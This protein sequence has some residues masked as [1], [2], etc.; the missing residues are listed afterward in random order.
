MVTTPRPIKERIE[1]I[2]VLRGFALL[3]IIIVHFVEQYYAGDPPAAIGSLNVKTLADE[4][5]TAV[6]GIFI[7][8]KFYIIFS[9]LFGLSFYVQLNNSDGTGKFFVR[10]AWR[11]IVLFALGFI[12]HLH[13]RGDIL[14][15]YA[16]LGFGLLL[17]S[18]LPDRALL[19]VALL[20]ILNVPSVV[21]RLYETT[22]PETPTEFFNPKQEEAY[23]YTVKSGTYL[24]ILKANFYEFETKA[25]VQ[26]LSGRA[27]ITLGLF[28][29]GLY[30]GRKKFFE[31]WKDRLLLIRRLRKTAWWVIAGSVACAAVFFGGLQL[32]KIQYHE[33]LGW[34][35]GGLFADAANFALSTVY[36][37]S[38]MIL[39]TKEKWHPR[40]MNFY[41]VGRMGLTTYLM[42]TFFGT[43]LFF[44]FGLGFLAEMGA[45]ACL[46]VALVVY[47]FQIEISKRWF[48]HFHY[49]LFE[50]IW[51]GLTYFKF[52]PLS[53]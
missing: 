35:I 5:V 45:M 20:L 42:Q 39:F 7:V 3:G 52:P 33:K 21:W 27:Y 16:V 46:A 32:L 12:H 2:D 9:F 51:R 36:V 11:L 48:E 41:A 38:V 14:T 22:L 50:W 49:G 44:S 19:V 25:R 18:G 1:I 29:L 15:I 26:I 13:Y 53:K 30:V 17:F 6:V 47:F 31:N 28:L 4:I 10:F 23:Y 34:A 40:L 37:L 24:E 43:F 8:G